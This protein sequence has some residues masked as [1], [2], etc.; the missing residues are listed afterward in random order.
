MSEEESETKE[1][2]DK[3]ERM[4][5]EFEV[6]IGETEG[7]GYTGGEIGNRPVRAGPCAEL[8]VASF[9]S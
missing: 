5:N 6:E 7:T 3:S 9:L 4:E 2:S 1:E 8:V